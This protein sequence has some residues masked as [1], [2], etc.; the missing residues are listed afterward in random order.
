MQCHV[1]STPKHSTQR[2]LHNTP[3][4]G[5]RRKNREDTEKIETKSKRV[6]AFG[7]IG[8]LADQFAQV[9]FLDE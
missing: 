8:N 7:L 6:Q 4:R 5:T 3:L 1:D 2:I 9:A